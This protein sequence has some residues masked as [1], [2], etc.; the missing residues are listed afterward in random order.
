MRVIISL[1]STSPHYL[2]P[3]SG[4]NQGAV[5][6]TK[7]GEPPAECESSNSSAESAGPLVSSAADIVAELDNMTPQV[8]FT[9]APRSGTHAAEQNL[10]MEYASPD[11]MENPLLTG[12]RSLDL[13][14]RNMPMLCPH[15]PVTPPCPSCPCCAPM[16]HHDRTWKS[17]A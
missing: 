8:P 4:P 15:A 13:S 16:P 11:H 17:M 3:C 10:H 2:W 12:S 6:T 7:A 14:W 9:P 1:G 5:D